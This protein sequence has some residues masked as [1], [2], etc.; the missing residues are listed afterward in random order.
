[1][2]CTRSCYL[3]NNKSIELAP[4]SDAQPKQSRCMECLTASAELRVWCEGCRRDCREDLKAWSDFCKSCCGCCKTPTRWQALAVLLCLWTFV[5]AC[6]AVM[7]AQGLSR[8]C[9]VSK[10]QATPFVQAC[11]EQWSPDATI[12]EVWAKKDMIMQSPAI[13]QGPGPV[14]PCSTHAVC[15]TFM[16]TPYAI[17]QVPS[18]FVAGA[19]NLVDCVWKTGKPVFFTAVGYITG[20]DQWQVVVTAVTTIIGT[21]MFNWKRNDQRAG[22]VQV[23]GRNS[24]AAM[25]GALSRGLPTTFPRQAPVAASAPTR[26]LTYGE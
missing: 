4:M 2:I 26:P 20:S 5:A 1:M 22:E 12:C 15:N 14:W 8:V 17:R 11:C 10:A 6:E 9:N 19:K 21:W 25:L 13:T 23:E 7:L 24:T 3:I 18:V 16:F